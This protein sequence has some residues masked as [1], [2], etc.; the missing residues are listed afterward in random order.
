MNMGCS[1]RRFLM[2]LRAHALLSLFKVCRKAV[3]DMDPSRPMLEGLS[4]KVTAAGELAAAGLDGKRIHVI[5]ID[6]PPVEGTMP[7]VILPAG[8][9]DKLAA[10][11]AGD[12]SEIVISG[13]ANRMQAASERIRFATKLM[14]G[15]YL[16]YDRFI[17][18]PGAYRVTASA[19]ALDAAISRLLVIPKSDSKGKRETTRAVRMT[20]RDGALLLE[21]KG[22][23]GDIEDV[24]PATIEGEGRPITFNHKYVRELIEA[25][26]E[27]D[28]TFAP[29][30]DNDACVRVLAQREGTRFMLFQRH[31]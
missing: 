2:G 3:S 11:F 13:N 30:P 6:A 21:M 7:G 17:P 9:V 5:A 12:E 28:I 10:I 27:G 16:D 22:N 8:S 29:T 25:V 31:F 15:D 19:K 24:V 26:G 4:L 14:A 18:E 23:D 1:F 20:P